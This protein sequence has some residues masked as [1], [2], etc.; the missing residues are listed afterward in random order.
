MPAQFE[1]Y[2][3]KKGGFR[4]RLKASNNQVSAVGESYP[5]KASCL[6]GIESIKKKAPKAEIVD[7]T[8]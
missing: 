3:D 8:N 2:K 6:N 7:L 1:I 5:K 4:F